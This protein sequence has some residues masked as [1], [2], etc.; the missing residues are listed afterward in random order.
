MTTREMNTNEVKS[1]FHKIKNTCVSAIVNFFEKHKISEL[2]FGEWGFSDTPVIINGTDDYD[3]YTLDK[4]VLADCGKVWLHCSSC[5]DNSYITA[6]KLP[7]E[8]L[9]DLVEWLQDNEEMIDEYLA[10]ESEE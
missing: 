5:Y 4:A 6:D 1:T 9:T 10:E 8:L 3:T 7:I 2:P